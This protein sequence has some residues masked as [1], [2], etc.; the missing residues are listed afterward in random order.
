MHRLEK[1]KH[2]LLQNTSRISRVEAALRSLTFV[3]PGT[4]HDNKLCSQT[5]NLNLLGLYHNSV[6]REAFLSNGYARPLSR[7]GVVINNESLFN[8][9]LSYWSRRSTLYGRCSSLLSTLVYTQVLMEIAVVNRWS[10]RAHWRFVALIETTKVVLRLILFYL[11]NQRMHLYPTHLKREVDPSNTF[12]RLATLGQFPKKASH[13][14]RQRHRQQQQQQQH[15]RPR[16]FNNVMDYLMSR[17]LTPDMVCRPEQMVS[18]MNALGT[19]GEL[20][21]ILRPLMYVLGVIHYGQT[22][23]KPWCLSLSIELISQRQSVEKIKDNVASSPGMTCTMMPLE[24]S[25]YMRRA[26]LV[27]FNVMRGAFFSRITRPFLERICDMSE[28]KPIVST[29][30]CEQIN[31]MGGGGE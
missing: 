21:F 1:Y 27:W 7:N 31:R 9:Y 4:L 25:E 15:R 10:Q 16:R 30:S 12:P 6:L 8:K 23:W 3:L 18:V 29:A 17:A 20:L 26:K 11:T 14:H 13:A 22:S 28:T 5:S 19:A 24:R 2:F